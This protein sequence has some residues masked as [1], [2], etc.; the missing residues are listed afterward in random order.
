MGLSIWSKNKYFNVNI[1][2]LKKNQLIERG[3]VGYFQTSPRSSIQVYLET[4]SAVERN[5]LAAPSF[6]F[7]VW[8]P[9][10]WAT[11][12]LYNN[13]NK[14]TC[15]TRQEI[16]RTALIHLNTRRMQSSTVLEEHAYCGLIRRRQMFCRWHEPIKL[17]FEFV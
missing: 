10:N 6:G 13:W 12:P 11:L 9:N 8:R 7:S 5:G 17:C 1:L 3:P 15:K 2:G 14:N 4:T 16:N